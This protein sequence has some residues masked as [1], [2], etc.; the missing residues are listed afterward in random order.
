MLRI[1]VVAVIAIAIGAAAWWFWPVPPPLPPASVPIAAAPAQPTGPRHVV[2]E[3]PA[4]TPLPKLAESNATMLEALTG[5]LGAEPVRNLFVVES[6]VRNIV[7]TID[8]LPREA[9]AGRLNP[10]QPVPGRMATT[11]REAT[12]AIA[13]ENARRYRPYVAALESVEPARLAGV[14]FRLYPLFQQAYV[15]LGYPNG[16]F[17][18]RL[19][20]VIDSLLEAPEVTGSVKLVAP[21]VLYEFA[22]PELEALPSGQKVLLRMGPENAARVKARLRAIRAE[23]VAQAPAH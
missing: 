9:Y 23:L 10:A 11:G 21:H 18:D 2:P 13:P 20:E 19:V 6:L 15:E 1:I 3:Q 8:N 14:Y 7:A 16:Y 22:D 4:A 5:V 12:L 17:N